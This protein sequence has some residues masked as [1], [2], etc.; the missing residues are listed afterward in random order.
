MKIFNCR[1]CKHSRGTSGLHTVRCFCEDR[2]DLTEF[3]Y[4]QD[5]IRN[6]AACV[7]FSYKETV[8]YDVDEEALIK[9]AKNV[10]RKDVDKAVS[11]D[12]I[13]NRP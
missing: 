1:N 3:G 5:R 11:D 2:E 12:K 6:R 10:S 9:N 7:H 13:D 4:A 8:L